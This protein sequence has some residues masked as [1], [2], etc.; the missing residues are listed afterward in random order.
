MPKHAYLDISGT[1]THRHPFWA[2]CL[3]QQRQSSLVE[4][5]QAMDIGFGV[6]LQILHPELRNLWPGVSNP[7]VG[8]NDVYVVNALGS[9]L[10]HGVGRVGGDGGI[11]FEEEN[12]SALR[13]WQVR[14]SL[15]CSVARVTVC[16]DDCVVWFGEIELKEASAETSAGAGNENDGLGTHG[17]RGSERL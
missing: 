4:P 13:L 11:D 9:K 8:D 7:C 16:G 14:Q 6:L 1:G 17:M 5:D 10:L 2:L 15:G 3:F 12:R